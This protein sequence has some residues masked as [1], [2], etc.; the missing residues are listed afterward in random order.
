LVYFDAPMA[1]GEAQIAG[2]SATQ[3][4]AA[5]IQIN[6]DNEVFA[7]SFY[8]TALTAVASDKTVVIQMRGN[9]SSY[10]KMD[11]IWIRQ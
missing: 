8:A 9:V 10:L 2:F 11:R 5:A 7:K 4:Y 1:E 3:R 6:Q